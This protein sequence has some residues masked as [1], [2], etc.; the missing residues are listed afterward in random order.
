MNNWNKTILQ[1]EFH[2]KVKHLLRL[3]RLRQKG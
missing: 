2:Q 3:L 1:T